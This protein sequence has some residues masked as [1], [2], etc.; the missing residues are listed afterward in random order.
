MTSLMVLASRWSSPGIKKQKAWFQS[1]WRSTSWDR[2]GTCS[3]LLHYSLD[4]TTPQDDRSYKI[5]DPKTDLKWAITPTLTWVFYK[6]SACSWPIFTWFLSLPIPYFTS[7]TQ[8]SITITPLNPWWSYMR[9]TP[10]YKD[11]MGSWE[12]KFHWR[13]GIFANNLSQEWQVD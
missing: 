1:Q 3:P 6:D 7:T 13:Q 9:M 5:H 4:P 8:I 11:K 12:I 10:S 2:I